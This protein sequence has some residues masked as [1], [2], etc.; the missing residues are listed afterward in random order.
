LGRRRRR[1]EKAVAVWHWPIN[2]KLGALSIARGT[3]RRGEK[4]GWREAKPIEATQKQEELFPK[5]I[6]SLFLPREGG[7]KKKKRKKRTKLIPDI[8]A[9]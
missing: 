9:Y 1:R 6:S 3:E 8:H 5:F 2:L 4:K 7:K